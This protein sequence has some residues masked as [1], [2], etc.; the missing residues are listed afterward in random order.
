MARYLRVKG[1]IVRQF[2]INIFGN[3]RFNSLLEKRPGIIR[4]KHNR[5]MTDYAKQLMEKQKLRYTYRLKENQMEKAI[6]KAKVMPGATGETVINLLERRLENVVYRSGMATTRGQA[7]QVVTQ[8]HILVDG[9]KI[10]APQYTVNPG[11][12]ISVHP[13]EKSQILLG[14]MIA[15][16][17]NG[18]VPSWISVSEK[19]KE[20]KIISLPKREEIPTVANENLVVEFY[21]K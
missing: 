17:K 8:G 3:P 6:N 1:K 4:K 15:K 21:S 5:P 11:E 19:G 12:L 10:T 18:T 13:K 20:A 16:P 14:K 9:K 2:G 7:R